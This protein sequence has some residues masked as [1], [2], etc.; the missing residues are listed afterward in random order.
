MAAVAAS[1]LAALAVIGWTLPAW[2]GAHSA[3][4]ARAPTTLLR[5]RDGA[6]TQ[7]VP[8]GAVA[9]KALGL[10]DRGEVKNCTGQ[11]TTGERK[12]SIERYEQANPNI[13]VQLVEFPASADEQRNQFIQHQEARSDDCDVFGPDV[14]WTAQFAQQK[15]QYDMTPYI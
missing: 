12:D 9:T 13:T 7:T 14:V 11:D 2:A 6:S 3:G 1:L 8:P 4:D 5:D 15:W 10:S